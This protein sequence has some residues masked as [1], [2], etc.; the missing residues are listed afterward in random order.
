MSLQME[1]EIADLQTRA[2]ELRT[3]FFATIDALDTRGEEVMGA[4]ERVRRSAAPLGLVT[5]AI[6]L[7]ALGVTAV[8]L[9]SRGAE[10]LARRRRRQRWAK[11]LA[12]LRRV[13]V[14][15]PSTSLVREVAREAGR[16]I[17]RAS[18]AE[19]AER[20]APLLVGRAARALAQK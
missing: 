16:V 15:Q 5:G 7:S 12:P 9:A 11:L 13:V 1:Q 19:T 17:A 20:I 4:A 6:A 8:W 2:T 14:V 3:R 18:L 10:R